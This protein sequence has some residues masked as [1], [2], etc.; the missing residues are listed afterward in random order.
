MKA[1]KDELVNIASSTRVE[2]DAVKTKLE[3]LEKTTEEDKNTEKTKQKL[4]DRLKELQRKYLQIFVQILELTA[5]DKIANF[6]SVL[7]TLISSGVDIADILEIIEA[8]SNT[9]KAA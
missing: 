9:D 7:K 4:D 8:K 3:E 1:F 6:K 2:I 5:G